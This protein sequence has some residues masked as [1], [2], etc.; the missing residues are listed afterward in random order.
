MIASSNRYQVSIEADPKLP[1]IR[2][3]RDFEATV[4][5]LMRAHTDPELVRALGWPRRDADQDPRLGRDDGWPLAL[6][7]W[8][9]PG[10]STASTGAFTRWRPVASCRPSAWTAC[11]TASPCR[12]VWFEDLSEQPVPDCRESWSTASRAATSGWP[13]ASRSACRDGYRKLDAV[14]SRAPMSSSADERRR[15]AHECATTVEGVSSDVVG[16]AGAAEGWRRPRRRP[17][18]RRVVSC[19]PADR[20]GNAAAGWSVGGRRP[21]R[22]LAHPH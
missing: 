7:C 20:H 10:R 22:C 21:C 4:A 9:R 17:P 13:A 2:I 19:V 5:Q 1:I 11:P 8:A 3:T 16:P 14:V 15:I 6:S 12:R 18:S